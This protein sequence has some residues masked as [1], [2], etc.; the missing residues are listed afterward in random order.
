MKLYF[1]DDKGNK[2]EIARA[3]GLQEGDVVLFLNVIYRE[4]YIREMENDLSLKMG[5]KV[6]ILDTRFRDIVV[7]P[8]C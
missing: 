4:Q 1:E 6:I 7:L 8:P 2:T 3:A 5:R